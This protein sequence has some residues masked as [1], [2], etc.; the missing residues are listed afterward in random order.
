[1]AA[2]AASYRLVDERVASVAAVKGLGVAAAATAVQRHAAGQ[3][4]RAG[5]FWVLLGHLH[6]HLPGLA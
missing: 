4:V 2:A 6:A 3:V 1:M 5:V